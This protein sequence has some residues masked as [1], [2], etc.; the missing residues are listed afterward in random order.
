M[1][2]QYY[3]RILWP[4]D[5]DHSLYERQSFFVDS[6]FSRRRRMTP[7]SLTWLGWSA[8]SI[9][10]LGYF[11]YVGVAGW[12]LWQQPGL[13]FWDWSVQVSWESVYGMAWPVFMFYL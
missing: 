8:L 12:K 13:S 6:R 7:R 11:I 5:F 2:E 10:T 3:D 1:L 9:Y 4:L